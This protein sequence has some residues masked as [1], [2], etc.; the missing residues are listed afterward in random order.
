MNPWP[1]LQLIVFAILLAVFAGTFIVEY[2][3]Q[4]RKRAAI[5]A[6]MAPYREGDF[7]AALHVA[8]RLRS[9]PRAYSFFQG[10]LL[11]ELGHLKE[12][13]PLLQQSIQLSEH[14]ELALRKTHFGT[15]RALKRQRKLTALSRSVLGQLYLDQ[16]LYD[17]ALRC[18]EASLIDWPGRGSSHRAIAEAMLRRGDDPAEALK[19]AR[20]AVDE[21]RIS[22]DMPREIRDT[23][24]G[25]DLAT[26][27]WAVAVASRDSAQVDRLVAEA[28]SVVGTR[29]VTSR[30]QVQYQSGLACAALGDLPRSTQHFNEAAR[31]DTRGRWGRAAR[32]AAHT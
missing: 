28:E 32:A 13:E 10:A 25:E 26:L 19:W 15:S 24:L 1:D 23:N 21:E 18:F 11:L 22:R 17:D 30:A 27:A 9:D 2:S 31:I 8:E 3:R 29:L 12:A 6:V 7:E 4:R 5:D 20:M 14:Q 16:G